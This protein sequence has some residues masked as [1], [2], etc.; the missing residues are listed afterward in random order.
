M[1]IHPRVGFKFH[2]LVSKLKKS[3][4]RFTLPDIFC[5]HFCTCSGEDKNRRRIKQEKEKSGGE[6]NRRRGNQEHEE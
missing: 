5:G 4:T 6:E 3:T 2:V 1:V